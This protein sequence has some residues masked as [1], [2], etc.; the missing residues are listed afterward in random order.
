[1]K[2][3][4]EKCI[5]RQEAIQ[6]AE[7]NQ[8]PVDNLW[9]LRIQDAY[10]K[11]YW[12]DLEMKGSSS[13]EILDRY[14]R[15]IW[16]ECC[17]HLSAFTHSGWRGEEIGKSRVAN[18]VFKQG[19]VLHHLYDFGQ[20]SE[21]DIKVYAVRVGKPTTNRPI[22]L[23]ARN[24]M[25]VESCQECDQVARW[26][27]QECVYEEGKPGLLCDQHAEE[28]PHDAYGE[29]TEIVNSPRIGMCGYEGPAEPPY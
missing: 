14:L 23:L 13:L 10:D 22:T 7:S 1:M 12:I 8:R 4:L 19:V 25:P 20:T 28:H 16:L 15:A 18:K 6:K 17:G 29:L 3:H 9:H 5:P 21:T 26:L 24:Q 11:D 27:C 2:K